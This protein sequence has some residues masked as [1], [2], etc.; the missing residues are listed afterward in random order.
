MENEKLI[1]SMCGKECGTVELTID[2]AGTHC[3]NGRAGTHHTG[4]YV[5]DC[6]LEDASIKR[7]DDESD[8]K[9]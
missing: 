9:I 2:Y 6:C 8:Y 7:K 3:N 1:C 5:S 4:E